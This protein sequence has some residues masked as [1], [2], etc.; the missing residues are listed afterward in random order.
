MPEVLAVQPGIGRGEDGR[1]TK[2]AVSRAPKLNLVLLFALCSLV[3]PYL[4]RRSS[5]VFD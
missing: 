4:L 5:R 1:Q 3:I 2:L